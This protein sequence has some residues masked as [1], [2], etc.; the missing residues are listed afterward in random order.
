[1]MAALQISVAFE[2]ASVA[3]FV[4]G[5]PEVVVVVVGI[6]ASYWHC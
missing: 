3:T 5:M 4:A 6:L 2:L 1:L